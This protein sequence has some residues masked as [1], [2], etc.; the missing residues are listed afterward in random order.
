MKFF[1]ACVL[2]PGLA[3]TALA[4]ESSGVIA[5][6]SLASW[7]EDGPE[8]AGFA[9]GSY[10]L[11]ADSLD[12]VSPSGGSSSS[13]T[14]GSGWWSWAMASTSSGGLLEAVNGRIASASAGTGIELA[15]TAPSSVPGA[16]VHGIAG[17]FSLLSETGIAQSGSLI[18]TLSDGTAATFKVS[19]ASAFQGF[20]TASPVAITG[21]TIQP[22]QGS[23]SLRV[24]IDNL[25][26]GLGGAVPAPGAI[27]LLAAAGLVGLRRRR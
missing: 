13:F 21:I 3:G 2:V 1:V 9:P 16:A 10:L 6:D 7:S 12:S 18:L 11:Q 5:Y 25:H 24:S 8:L 26:F 14:G 19:A 4:S 17:D 27:A 20:W 23:T 22:D 15:L